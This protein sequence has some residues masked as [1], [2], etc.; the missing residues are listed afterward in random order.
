MNRFLLKTRLK[1]S[2]TIGYCIQINIFIPDKF[3]LVDCNCESLELGDIRPAEDYERLLM[4]KAFFDSG[5]TS[6]ADFNI[7]KNKMA[8]Q[9]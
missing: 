4:F 6:D 7:W 8:A 1:V 3:G 9:K 5:N 2:R